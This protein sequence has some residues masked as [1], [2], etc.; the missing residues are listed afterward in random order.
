M[1]QAARYSLQPSNAAGPRYV[2]ELSIVNFDSELQL[3]KAP[4]PIEVTEAGM[5]KLANEL[6]PWKAP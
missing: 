6:Q 2:V 4:P 1:P 5:V 3:R